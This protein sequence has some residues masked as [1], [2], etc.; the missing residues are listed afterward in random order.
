M[1]W[2]YITPVFYSIEILPEKLIPIFKLN[3]LYQYLNAAREIV[4]YSKCPSIYNLIA[5]TLYSLF[6]IIVG[7]IIFKKNQDKFVYYV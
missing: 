4:L 5:I 2:N 7:G 6:A 3:P 1:I